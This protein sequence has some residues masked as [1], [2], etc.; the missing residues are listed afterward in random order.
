MFGLS[1]IT[2]V[3]ISTPDD[4]L[5]LTKGNEHCRDWSLTL[6]AFTNI[7]KPIQNTVYEKLGLVMP[8]Q[9][10]AFMKILKFPVI[11]NRDYIVNLYFLK[12]LTVASLQV[13]KKMKVKA[14]LWPELFDDVHY[15]FSFLDYSYRTYHGPEYTIN[16]MLAAKELHFKG[17]MRK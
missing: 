10:N 16:A 11:K 3:V 2:N 14:I 6:E 5:I 8:E 13:N 9:S 1:E 15:E 7:D 17:I 12:L 4:R